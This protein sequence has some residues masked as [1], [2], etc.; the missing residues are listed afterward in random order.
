MTAFEEQLMKN[1]PSLM[2]MDEYWFKY[3]LAN[4]NTT[5]TETERLDNVSLVDVDG[6]MKHCKDN[7]RVREAADKYLYCGSIVNH[8]ACGECSVCAFKKELG[9]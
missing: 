2:E 8:G 4:V 7:Q 6:V 1:F 3:L 5:V 9:L